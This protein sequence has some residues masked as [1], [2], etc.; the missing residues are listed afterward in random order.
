MENDQ[1]QLPNEAS[2]NPLLREPEQPQHVETRR[3]RRHHKK[4]ILLIV[5]GV[6]LAL[7][8]AA[9]AYWFLVRATSEKQAPVQAPGK[10]M[11][12][13]QPSAQPSADP[14]PVAYKSTKLNIEITHRKD[15]TMKEA[16]DGEL[17][18]TSPSTSFVGADG[19]ASMGVFTV[20]IR[21][22]AKEAMQATIDK[23]FATKDSKVIA[24]AAP[25]E[26]QR[27]YTNVSYL[28]KTKD[29]FNFFIVTGST[30]F[31]TGNAVA[32][33]LP[34]A[35]DAYLIAGGY[36]TAGSALSFESI[37]KDSMDSA[38][39]DQAI[40]IAESLKIY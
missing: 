31:K 32:Y 5:G 35:S 7:L 1:Q 33:A 24:Y 30:E 39:L 38:T 23:S 11:Q 34:I 27:Q 2:H 40:A 10:E 3:E 8:L 28:G 14:T 16:S 19:Q 4:M 13:E 9:A 21:K 15:W 12:T 26:Q 22:G 20:I 6:V 25:T 37:P 17:T 18:F 29:V 36:G